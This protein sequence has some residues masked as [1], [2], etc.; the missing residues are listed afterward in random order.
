MTS[1]A[2]EI[3]ALGTAA[4]WTV[5]A[6][7]FQQATR[8][9]GSLSV[10]IIRLFIA[11]MLFGLISTLI[12]GE[13][14][15][16]DASSHSWT[17]LSVSGL[18]GFVLGDYWLF[19][20]YNYISARISMLIMA[21]SPLFAALISYFVLSESMGWFS[22]FAMFITLGGIFMVV[23]S[24][25]AKEENSTKRGR[26]QF[27]FPVKGLL[28][29]LGGAV[30]QAAGLVLSK[31]GMGDY[32]AFASTHIRVIAGLLGF[33]IVIF[34][35]RRWGRVYESVLNK[36]AMMFTLVGGIFGPFLGVYLSL[37]SVKH[38][39]V[40]IGSTLMSIVPVLIIPFVVIIYKEKVTLR[41]LAGAIITVAG[42]ALFFIT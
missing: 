20:S 38:T 10:N 31:Y 7:A 17:W 36:K 16:S 29:A 12:R 1:Y 33:I 30:G 34:L 22:I 21:V 37:Y 18:I 14:I 3:A 6:L 28:F 9:I 5:T 42:V 11:F 40:G 39:S 26:F 15:P 19:M 4:C 27:S 2:G 23:I 32:D 25:A 35:T 13:F 24:R 8:K 41:E